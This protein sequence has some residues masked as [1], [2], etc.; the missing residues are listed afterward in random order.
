MFD[1]R[2]VS[3]ERVIGISFV[4]ILIQAVFLLLLILIVGYID[5]VDFLLIKEYESVGKD[6]CH[7]LNKDSPKAC[8]ELIDSTQIGPVEDSSFNKLGSDV[9]SLLGKETP[10]DCQK[11]LNKFIGLKPCIASI[12]I[13]RAPVSVIWEINSSDT[14][15]FIGF[16]NEYIKY[17]ER[18]RD[19]ARLNIVKKLEAKI[20][21]QMAPNE[22]KA[23]FSFLKEKTCFHEVTQERT[24]ALSNQQIKDLLS[25]IY[26]LKGLA[27]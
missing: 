21:S 3:R 4:D 18:E 13:V 23:N 27:N 16:S 8:R 15:K 20:G 22:I 11:S 1:R 26:S 9:C 10:E 24:A 19:E 6:L 14:A 7:K 12:D 25:A 2:G 5:P 17:L